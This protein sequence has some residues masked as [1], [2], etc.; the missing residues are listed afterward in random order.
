MKVSIS[1]SLSSSVGLLSWGRGLLCSERRAQQSPLCAGPPASLQRRPVPASGTH[2]PLMQLAARL[3][4]SSGFTEVGCGGG[5]GGG[6]GDP[7]GDRCRPAVR[8]VASHVC[9]AGASLKCAD[10]GYLGS[11]RYENRFA[12]L[13]R[14]GRCRSFHCC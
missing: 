14:A 12:V 7:R 9:P 1:R 4:N 2:A 13:G 8:L 11:S 3:R 5:C 10:V 6:R